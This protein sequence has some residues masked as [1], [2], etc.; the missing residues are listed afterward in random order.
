MHFLQSR[1]CVGSNSWL[2]SHVGQAN[3][4]DEWAWSWS[5]L[6]VSEV[7]CDL[8]DE[9]ARAFSALHM[10]LCVGLNR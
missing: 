8:D 7:L 1:A 2:F 6:I 9:E 5:P 4:A 3:L 10:I